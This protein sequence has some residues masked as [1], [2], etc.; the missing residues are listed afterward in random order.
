MCGPTV[1]DSAHLGHARTYV[2][3]DI[4]SRI[5]TEFFG[6]HV[7]LAMNI[8]D[9][10]D[11][12]INRAKEREREWSG[13]AREFE[14]E[15][16]QD[17]ALMNVRSPT[18]VTRV[19]EYIAEVVSMIDEIVKKGH[20]Y[21][22]EDGVYFS[23]ASHPTY[24]KLAPKSAT[25]AQTETDDDTGANKRDRRDFALWKR[26][27]EGEPCWDSPWG[28][29]RPGWHIECSAMCHSIFGNHL[30][31]H[32]GGVD[33]KF[34]HHCNEIAQ[35]EAAMEVPHWPS[36]FAHTGH[37]YIKGLKM[38]KSLKNFIT[39]RELLQSGVTPDQFRLFCLAHK[40]SHNIEYSS[41]RMDES[42]QLQSKILDFFRTAES[43]GKAAHDTEAGDV[44]ETVSWKWNKANQELEEALAATRGEVRSAL[45]NDFDTPSAM[46]SLR[47]LMTRTNSLMRAK[48]SE[49][50]VSPSPQIVRVVADYLRS[51]LIGFGLGF[52]KIESNEGSDV[53]MVP[54]VSGVVE[55]GL[56]F[57]NRVRQ[58]CLDHI[59]TN[60]AKELLMECDAFRDQQLPEA[61]IWVKD[62]TDGSSTWHLEE[63]RPQTKAALRST[64][65]AR[66][67]WKTRA[68]QQ[69]L[70]PEHIFLHLTD[71]YSAFDN[72][73]IPT[74]NAA[75][76]ALSK[77]AVKRLK[78]K[79][80]KHAAA[81]EKAAM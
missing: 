26:A 68:R 62:Q 30:D 6:Y 60:L 18:V 61:G 75:G 67:G 22:T 55:A 2:C 17:M 45:C 8:T 27:K 74:H 72:D 12:I 43:F 41:D 57:R 48:E 1:Y 38:S 16:F 69:G 11:K 47:D 7:K 46:K 56:G 21:T 4:M 33:L 39:V 49:A 29:G 80:R 42:R 14:A 52:V 66:Q 54:A 3:F 34:P 59:D 53:D 31:L 19:S 28:E 65:A 64:T 36:H 23:V 40:Y 5:L 73:G 9:I 20:G 81:L 44:R 35:C 15:F 70:A 37:L 76:E 79:Q 78:A 71:E 77:K 25:E 51:T 50:G 58:T 13:L 32:T 10:D 63:Y 24:G